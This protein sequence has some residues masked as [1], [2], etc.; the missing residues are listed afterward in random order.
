MSKHS[1]IAGATIAARLVTDEA[2]A[3]WLA[4]MLGETLD[5]AE[6]AVAA[7]ELTDGHWC[8]ALHFRQAPRE[9]QI[10]ELVTRAA[11]AAAGKALTFETLP[12][13]DWA[14]A[15]LAG[16]KP[17]VAGRFVVHGRH[18][19]G[20][21]AAN[22]IAIEIYAGLAF[23]T[24]HHGTTR[25]CLL[26]LDHVAKRWSK[27]IRDVV[28]PGAVQRAPYQLIFANILLAPLQRLACPLARLLAP[29]APLVLSGLLVAQRQ[30]ALAS[31]LAQGLRL[32]RTIT[33][34]GWVTLLLRR[35]LPRGHCRA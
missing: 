19:R 34:G 35:P 31:Y 17:V 5:P 24:V 21:T 30:A 12:A 29:G 20:R 2:N 25:G 1:G 7:F 8:V 9:R 15:S 27:P 26:A 18:D 16:L 13:R 4:A 6:T 14:K 22:A 3:R 32:E 33:L 28:I 23:G 10:R 11:G